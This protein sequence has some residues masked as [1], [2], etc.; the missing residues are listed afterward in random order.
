MSFQL[1]HFIVIVYCYC[2]LL[3]CRLIGSFHSNQTAPLQDEA[4]RQVREMLP[5]DIYFNKPKM[6]HL[7]SGLALRKDGN[8]NV[9]CHA[10]ARLWMTVL[11]QEVEEES[12]E[13]DD[14]LLD[15]D[16]LEEVCV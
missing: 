5:V 2:L 6:R 9:V 12:D 15:D 11:A 14:N 8:P 13:E 16:E 3:V 10:R 1:S 7:P 4:E